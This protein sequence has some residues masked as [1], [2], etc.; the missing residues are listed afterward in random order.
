MVTMSVHILHEV[1]NQTIIFDLSKPP[2][3]AYTLF[4]LL[5][6][7]QA[8][9]MFVDYFHF[10]QGPIKPFLLQSIHG[11]PATNIAECIL[12]HEARAY[13]NDEKTA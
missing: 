8:E 12:I 5:C 2:D 6:L 13:M 11:S 3:G 10:G 7:I 4:H 1:H 9:I